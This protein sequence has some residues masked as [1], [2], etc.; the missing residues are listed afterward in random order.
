MEK[1]KNGIS[2]KVLK[3]NE[4]TKEIIDTYNSLSDAGKKNI[5]KLSYDSINNRCIGRSKNRDGYIWCYEDD[6]INNTIPSHRFE[7]FRKLED[8]KEKEL[9]EI[10]QEYLNGK[11]IK[12]LS[13]K[14]KMYYGTM[15]KHILEI[16]KPINNSIEYTSLECKLTGEIFDDVLNI[17]GILTKHIMLI[18][19]DVKLE[20]KYKRK[21]I[22]LKTGSFWFMKYFNTIK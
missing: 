21:Q 22:E 7:D 18:Y 10:Y 2:K 19:P 14:Y 4:N 3:I 15:H 13:S 20:S 17:S 5:D 16:L 9:S 11:S 6:F 8:F 12:E 1:T